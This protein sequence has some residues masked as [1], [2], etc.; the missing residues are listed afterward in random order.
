M[1]L[2]IRYIFKVISGIAGLLIISWKLTI[3]VLI[4]VPVKYFMV[5][6]LSQLKE[7]KMEDIIES[8]RDFSA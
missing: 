1:V 7:R 4:M 3:V 6:K 8:H 2:N 5:Q